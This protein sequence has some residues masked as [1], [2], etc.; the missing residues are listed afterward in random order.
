MALSERAYQI[1]R[2]AC[3]IRLRRG[4]DYKDFI[5]EYPKLSSEQKA[6]I[7]TDIVAKIEEEKAKEGGQE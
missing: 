6:N 2:D 4:E 1:T 3:L 5:E 7:I